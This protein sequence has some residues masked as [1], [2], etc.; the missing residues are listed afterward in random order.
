MN[1]RDHVLLIIIAG[2][3]AFTFAGSTDGSPEKLVSQS[4]NESTH[5]ILPIRTD[6][7]DAPEKHAW[8]LFLALMHP[9]KDPK[10]A[11]GVPDCNKVLGTSGTTATWETWRLANTEVFLGNGAEPP[12]WEDTKL[13]T[14]YFGTTPGQILKIHEKPDDK[15]KPTFDP[16]INQSIFVDHGGIGETRMNK[17][18]YNFIKENC[19][20]SFDGLSRYS[21]AILD[22]KKLP[23]NFPIDSQEVKAVWIEFTPDQL[24]EGRENTYY[25]IVH[26]GKTYGMTSFHILTK[27]TPNWFWATFHHRQ[28]PH[29]PDEELSRYPVP[30]RA[31]GTVWENYALGG[32]QLDFITS[33]GKP[34]KLS[35]YY[36]EY[37]FTAS[38]CITCHASAKGHPDP[39]RT[40]DGKLLR[41]RGRIVASTQGPVQTTDLGVPDAALFLKDGKPYYQQT[42]FLWSIPFRA[43]EEQ[44]PPPNRCIF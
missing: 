33:T 16:A 44:Q 15:L 25:H 34:T 18:T 41:S 14:G 28:T 7:L 13:P 6:A 19:L 3:T 4:P 21:K 42:D 36:I 5:C 38:S 26:E 1:H 23:I 12:E 29:N 24:K 39:Q 40:A 9:A 22:K 27:D 10:G 32:T 31:K 17:S 8:D 35:D 30:V 2:Y 37:D 20:W 43:Q 11:R